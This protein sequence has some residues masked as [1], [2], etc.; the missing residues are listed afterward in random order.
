MP[1]DPAEEGPVTPEVTTLPG[2]GAG[3]GGSPAWPHV[4]TGLCRLEAQRCLYVSDGQAGGTWDSPE[5]LRNTRLGPSP[6]RPIL[7]KLMEVCPWLWVVL[8][9]PWVTV[10]CSHS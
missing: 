4:C 2:A 5:R 9:A 3:P 1:P 8:K 10:M 7:V 6:T